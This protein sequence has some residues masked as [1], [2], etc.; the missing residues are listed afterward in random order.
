MTTK[1]KTETKMNHTPPPITRNGKYICPQCKKSFNNAPGYRLHHVRSHR[2]LNKKTQT[3][4]EPQ[5]TLANSEKT[6]H[7][8][9]KDLVAK[10]LMSGKEMHIDEIVTEIF[11]LGY[12]GTKNINSLKTYISALVSRHPELGITKPHKGTYVISNPSSEI[13]PIKKKQKR[14][15]KQ[16]VQEIVDPSVDSPLHRQFRRNLEVSMKLME[17]LILSMQE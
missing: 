11:S 5:I 4:S 3:Q 10:V 12:T 8:Q 14:Q 1:T 17:A 2:I 16:K 7:G 9:S 6:Q 13:A 15:R